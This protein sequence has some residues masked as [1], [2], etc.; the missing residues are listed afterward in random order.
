MNPLSNHRKH[1]LPCANSSEA[2][3][4]SFSRTNLEND[5]S[6]TTVTSLFENIQSELRAAQTKRE[7]ILLLENAAEQSL[8]Q[9]AH[10]L[11]RPAFAE[12]KQLYSNRGH[13]KLSKAYRLLGS[14]LDDSYYRNNGNIEVDR[15]RIRLSDLWKMLSQAKAELVYKV[16]NANGRLV[17]LYVGKYKNK[18]SSAFVA[19]PQIRRITNV[20]DPNLKSDSSR[21]PFLFEGLRNNSALTYLALSR[22]DPA[23]GILGV[24]DSMPNLKELRLEEF[25]FWPTF[26][27]TSEKLNFLPSLLN[28]LTFITL[29][30]SHI[31][32]RIAEIFGIALANNQVL[33]Y[34]SLS[35]CSIDDQSVRHLANGLAN[36]NTLRKLFLDSNEF[37][38]EGVK[39]I[40]RALKENYG[41]EMLNLEDIEMSE[42]NVEDFIDTLKTNYTLRSLVYNLDLH[43]YGEKTD[44]EIDERLAENHKSYLN[45]TQSLLS[46]LLENGVCAESSEDD[47]S[48]DEA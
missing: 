17:T 25:H 34:L 2:P 20:V 8:I 6:R 45:K 30:G 31:F 11:Y 23:K 3:T 14:I 24:L 13:Q 29:D 44:E 12:L 4:T 19:L 33:E 1:G 39:F 43:F 38:E 35:S 42:T 10:Q 40:A 18:Y 28:R 9:L 48:L 7:E 41:L 26:L 21:Q 37:G 22:Y 32:V 46:M 27:A 36:N 15:K 16:L 5:A 47:S